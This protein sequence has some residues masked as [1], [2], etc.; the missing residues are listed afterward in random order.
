MCRVLGVQRSGFYAY[1]RN[2]ISTRD[3]ENQ[4][5]LIKI[6]EEYE[7]SKQIYG[8]PRITAMLHKQGIACSRPRV[9]RLMK[10]NDIRSV[11]RRKFKKQPASKDAV[12]APNLLNQNFI[13]TEPDSIWISDIT[14]IFTKEGWLYLTTI[15][16]LFNREIISHHKSRTLLTDDT[17]IP[18]FINAY[19]LRKPKEG[20]IFHS[21]KGSQYTSGKFRTLLSSSG[22]IQSMSSAGNCYDNAVSESFFKTIKAELIYLKKGGYKTIKEA[23]ADI[24]E[25]IEC[26]YNTKRLHSS[27]GF[28]SPKE[29][30]NNRPL[31]NN[32]LAA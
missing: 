4:E 14:Y 5:L 27:L 10:K 26:F 29:Y 18:A 6:K 21:D 22:V 11:I 1:L 9:A 2:P 8:S 25:Y 28:Q 24:F 17:V 7:N 3:K 23:E 19:N 15:M 30:L 12:I 32:E 31:N 13:A 16:D 20:L